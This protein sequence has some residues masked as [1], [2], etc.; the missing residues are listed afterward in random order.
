MLLSIL[1]VHDVIKNKTAK[2]AVRSF[3]ILHPTL[4]SR[5]N[6]LSRP[7]KEILA[8]I[9]YLPPASYARGRP[10]RAQK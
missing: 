7:S 6:K 8:S 9:R 1:F 5:Q 10:G 4:P 3:F 2:N